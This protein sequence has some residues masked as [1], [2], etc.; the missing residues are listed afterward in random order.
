M[1]LEESFLVT[2]GDMLIYLYWQKPR[3]LQLT[4]EGRLLK[5]HCSFQVFQ[6]HP[7]KAYIAFHGTSNGQC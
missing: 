7:H 3:K 2:K 5:R 4:R 6:D 1:N